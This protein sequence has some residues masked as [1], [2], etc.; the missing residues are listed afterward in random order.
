MTEIHAKLLEIL[1]ELDTI[2]K[3][4]DAEYFLTGGSALGAIRHHGF[5][6]WD[7]DIDVGMRRSEWLKIRPFIAEE[8][9]PSMLVVDYLEYPTYRNPII[10]IVDTNSTVL[11]KTPLANECPKGQYIEV[12]IHDPVPKCYLSQHKEDFLVYCEL[13]SSYFSVFNERYYYKK[14]LEDDDIANL[15]KYIHIQET[16]TDDTEKEVL[17]AYEREIS[18]YSEEE[19]DYLLL[20]WGVN[21]CY[22]PIENFY[23]IKYEQFEDMIV[24]VP[25]RACDNLRIDYGNSWVCYPPTDSRVAH[26]TVGDA[27]ICGD[28]YMSLI[29]RQVDLATNRKSRFDSKKNLLKELP[30]RVQTDKKLFSVLMKQA[31]DIEKRTPELL[32]RY[33]NGEYAW[34]TE[35]FKSYISLKR[36]TMSYSFNE[37]ISDEAKRIVGRSLVMQGRIS[38]AENVLEIPRN[39]R[40]EE[41][42]ERSEELGDTTKDIIKINKAS[43][44]FYDGF[45]GKASDLLDS[46]NEE[47]KASIT[48]RK[49]AARIQI[50]NADN[51]NIHALEREIDSLVHANPDDMELQKIKG[52]LM[53][54]QGK[55][56]E[57]KIEYAEVLNKSN[58]GIDILDIND[59]ITRRGER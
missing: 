13:L 15:E 16:I 57:A 49:I 39:M 23:G 47:F 30:Y 40:A 3:R 11:Y 5:I 36:R 34:I 46:I 52:D 58:N 50:Q 42:E 10:R 20:E 7:D 55:E 2:C 8:L 38:E 25:A 19:S 35:L 24:P 9:P 43:A 51:T 54:I 14:G 29:S 44:L 22:Y 41:A 6:P 1:K 27:S 59:K 21:C 53:W 31:I 28:K 32:R 48:V 18:K 45:L 26:V 56:S 33:E 12:F 37:D 17:A 4:H